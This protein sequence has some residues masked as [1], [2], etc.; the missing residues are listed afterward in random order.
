M[1]LLIR[2]WLGLIDS[3][4]TDLQLSGIDLSGNKFTNTPETTA[5]INV[6]W[7]LIEISEGAVRLRV[8]AVY[9]GDQWF[10]PFN[11]KLSNPSDTF[12]NQQLQQEAYWLSNGRLSWQGKNLSLVLWGRNLADEEYYSYGLDLRSIT[13]SDYLVRGARRTY[14]LEASYRF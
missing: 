8:D 5:N 14:G 6:D 13:G 7:K 3:E 11:D 4:Y 12:G 1:P 10:S 9:I 2:W